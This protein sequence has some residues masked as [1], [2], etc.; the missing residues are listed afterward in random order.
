MFDLSVLDRC[1][2]E[3][4]AEPACRACTILLDPLRPGR[5]AIELPNDLGLICGSCYE[6][7]RRHMCNGMTL[8]VALAAATWG[9]ADL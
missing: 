6:V 5:E 8:S 2:P 4:A 3:P 9:T 1:P 7:M